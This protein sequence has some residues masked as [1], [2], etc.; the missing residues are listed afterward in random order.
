MRE[1]NWNKIFTV[2]HKMSV[3][4]CKN[5]GIFKLC[6]LQKDK[7]WN[8]IYTYDLKAN[9]TSC[10]LFN[11]ATYSI[12]KPNCITENDLKNLLNGK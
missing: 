11:N 3:Y 12:E 4:E 8:T 5:C 1:H 7:M 2:Y 10:Y 6:T 9:S